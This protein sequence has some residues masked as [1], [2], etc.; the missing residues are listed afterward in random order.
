M[1]TSVG[2]EVMNTK[3]RQTYTVSVGK[4]QKRR[5]S[6]EFL[7]QHLFHLQ[8]YWTSPR[9][10]SLLF[11]QLTNEISFQKQDNCSPEEMSSDV[12]QTCNLV[13]VGEG[14]NIMQMSIPFAVQEPMMVRKS[15]KCITWRG[16]NTSTA[17]NP[18]QNNTNICCPKCHIL[19]SHH[20]TGPTVRL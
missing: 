10:D 14:F 13:T 7:L 8:L 1:H 12:N 18:A 3:K 9:M 15:S 4:E 6:F 2:L 19:S 11:Y 16:H 17:R 5:K 20:T